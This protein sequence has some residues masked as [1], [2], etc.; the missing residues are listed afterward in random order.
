MGWASVNFFG[1]WT[2]LMA[3]GHFFSC[4]GYH[5]SLGLM[6]LGPLTD[7][8]GVGLGLPWTEKTDLYIK[9]PKK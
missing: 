4:L 8:W 6:G 1:A 5:G 2:W 3:F 7:Y 9:K